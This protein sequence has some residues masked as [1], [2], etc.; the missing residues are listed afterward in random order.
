MERREYIAVPR[1]WF[2]IQGIGVEWAY[3]NKDQQLAM[4]DL[5][6]RT[7]EQMGYQQHKMVQI[8]S[9][10]TL[11]K[12]WGWSYHRT[13]KFLAD[14][15][16]CERIKLHKIPGSSWDYMLEWIDVTPCFIESTANRV[17][18][19]LGSLEGGPDGDFF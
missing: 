3:F 18:E 19:F 7:A 10:R 9:M 13:R 4:W 6:T 14:L 2:F 11:A 5:L 8:P 15:V 1:S 12:D 16:K 17:E